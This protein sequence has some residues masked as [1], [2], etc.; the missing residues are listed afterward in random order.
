MTKNAILA[1]F[2]QHTKLGPT[3]AAELLG[4]PYSTYA[5][6]RNGT[7]TMKTHT[8][9]HIQALEHLAPD[10]LQQIIKEHVRDGCTNE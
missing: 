10:T 2:E 4:V 9:R 1:K 6:L 3:Y 8:Q 7:R 5:Q